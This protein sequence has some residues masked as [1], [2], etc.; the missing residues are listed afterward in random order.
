[1]QICARVIGV[2]RQRSRFDPEDLHRCQLP[3]GHQGACSEYHYLAS[4]AGTAPRVRNKII[5]DATKTTGASWNSEDAGPNRISRWTM[6]MTNEQ[7]VELGIPMNTLSPI[8][9][10][11]LREKAA[12]YDDCMGAARKLAWQAYGM[13]N[14]PVPDAATKSYLESFYGPIIPGTTSC[15]I[16]K[17]RLDFGHFENA[18]RGRADIETA[19]ATPR[20]HNATN[21]G[22]AHRACNIAQGNMTLPEFYD[23][24]RGI[25][26]R[27]GL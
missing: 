27:N 10:R 13:L 4:M 26:D 15:L 12:T 1:M 14:A 6:L 9:Q 21:V 18:R 5:R 19:H 2:G 20:E 11:K 23:W 24:M 8:I 3:E 22:F 25:L 7:L 17:D 16:C